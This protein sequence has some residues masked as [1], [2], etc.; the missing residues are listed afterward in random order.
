MLIVVFI[1]VGFIQTA[2]AQEAISTATEI[3]AKDLGV[4]NPGI[5][6]TSPFYFLK[7]IKRAAQ[8][9]FTLD[10]VKKADLEL[11]IVNEQAAEIK[12][13]EEVA[14]ERVNAIARAADNYQQDMERLKQRLESIQETSQNP[15]ID[16]LA[17]KIA[18]NFIKHQQLFSELKSKFE[19]NEE[20]KV[21]LEAAQEKVG[22]AV[23]K[24]PEK[25]DNPE[26]FRER[27][28]RV[29]KNQPNGIVNELKRIEIIDRI[30]EKIPVEQ[31]QGIE[32]AKDN[33][34]K[35]FGGKIEQLPQAQMREILRPEFLEMIPGDAGQRIKI[36]EEIKNKVGSSEVREKLM[37]AGE[38]IL[39]TKIENREITKE[40]VQRMINYV[41]ELV[42]KADGVLSEIKDESVKAN[43]QKILEKIKARLS[44]AEKAL[45]EDKIGEAFG[46]TNSAGA[47]VK[48][49]LIPVIEAVE[50]NIKQILPEQMQQKIELEIRQIMPI[51]PEAGSGADTSAPMMKPIPT[52]MPSTIGPIEQIIKPLLPSILD[53]KQEEIRKIEINSSPIREEIK[54]DSIINS[55]APSVLPMQQ[56]QPIMQ[57]P[58]MINY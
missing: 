25:F 39:E 57:Q 26:M 40:E 46:I 23:A 17:E 13:L 18:D 30:S 27:L 48:R 49:L 9:V 54:S 35:E 19:N 44:E 10:P 29:V 37:Q 7:N 31:R 24:V 47:E 56:T 45:N 1:S 15:N 21:K 2:G 16:K 6:P 20:V 12:K 58:Y 4:E 55:V 33:L 3:T 5:L 11:N 50:S 51:K 8:R 41:K 43:K 52:P 36:I 53:I 32:E 28:E 42:A 34:I 22:E 14:P 38:R